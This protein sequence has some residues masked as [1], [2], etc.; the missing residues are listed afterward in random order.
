QVLTELFWE[1][2]RRDAPQHPC[3]TLGGRR[4]RC[5]IKNRLCYLRRVIKTSLK[6]TVLGQSS[7]QLHVSSADGSK[8]LRHVRRI[9]VRDQETVDLVVG[10][11]KFRRHFLC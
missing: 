10:P 11:V 1:K 7:V 5:V 3:V 2:V 9:G 6:I 4:R 8:R